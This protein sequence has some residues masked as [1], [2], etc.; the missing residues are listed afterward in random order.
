M[1]SL[2]CWSISDTET[3]Q[4]MALK[5]VITQFQNGCHLKTY[6]LGYVCSIHLTNTK[7]GRDGQFYALINFWHMDSDKIAT[8]AC[9]YTI[10]KFIKTLF[11]RLSLYV[12]SV[13][14]TNTKIGRHGHFYVL[15]TGMQLPQ[16][17]KMP[18]I[19]IV[20]RK[21]IHNIVTGQS[22]CW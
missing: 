9:Y 3:F 1:G 16:V 7:F 10:S 2:M 5:A 18:E 14:L 21:N 4:K 17:V 13:H 22:I 12:C 11:T 8:E 6:L 19:T 20:L 15:I